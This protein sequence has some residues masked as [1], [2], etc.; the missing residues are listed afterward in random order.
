M[1]SVAW[2]RPQCVLVCQCWLQK[3]VARSVLS[4]VCG[5]FGG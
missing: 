5:G 1:Q 2:E 4:R 3:D